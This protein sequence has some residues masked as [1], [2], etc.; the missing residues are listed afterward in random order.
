MM[1]TFPSRHPLP[2]ARSN[3]SSLAEIKSLVCNQC[4]D[5]VF[6]TPIYQGV[7]TPERNANGQYQHRTAVT[8]TTV[9]YVRE[10]SECGCAWCGFLCAFLGSCEKPQDLEIPYTASFSFSAPQYNSTPVGRNQFY[11]NI[12]PDVE[13]SGASW[14]LLLSAYTS[15]TD[16]AAKFVT[17]RPLETNVSSPNAG[18]QI[19]TWM[20]DCEAHECC[21]PQNDVPLPS[22]VIEVSPKDNPCRPRLI[23]SEGRTGK[24]ATLSYCWGSQP[25]YLLTTSN[26]QQLREGLNMNSIPQ[27]IRDAISVATTIPVDYLWI[28][29]LCILQDSN[30]DKI[31]ELAKMEH[32]YRDSLVTIVAASANDVSN[33]LLECR[34]GTPSISEECNVWTNR[35]MDGVSKLP[36]TIPFRIADG[37]FGT[38]SLKCVECETEYDESKEPINT[39]AWTTQEQLMAQRVLSY[40]SHTLQW[41]CK[42]GTQNLGDSL[43]QDKYGSSTISTLS[44]SVQTPRDALLRWLRIVEMYSPRRLTLPND[45]LPAIAG[46]AKEFSDCLGPSYYAGIWVNDLRTTRLYDDKAFALPKYL[47]P[48]WSWASVDSGVILR[49][50]DPEYDEEGDDPKPVCE[51]FHIETTLKSETLPYGE[52]TAGRLKLRGKLR[53][54]WLIKSQEEDEDR[55]IAWCSESIYSAAVAEANHLDWVKEEE[56]LELQDP[57]GWSERNDRNPWIKAQFDTIEDRASLLVTCFPLFADFGL[58]LMAQDEKGTYKRIGSFENHRTQKFDFEHSPIEE[59]TII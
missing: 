1:M 26:I 54:G 8:K 43:H 45:K 15:E 18:K 16:R 33:G 59:V 7:C 2:S 19:A 39:R 57:D 14:S 23:S 4:W 46:I 27:T 21:A 10:S 3:Y 25:N 53:Q 28:D 37:T 42:A 34:P 58:I 13:K 29:A 9:R 24:Y 44:I 6:N 17:A 47:A 36:W 40:A 51:V 52:V 32:I 5:N 49:T 12:K 41:R 11:L 56:K 35:R 31:I 55:T 22:R 38:M 48:S 30:E 50:W 20:R